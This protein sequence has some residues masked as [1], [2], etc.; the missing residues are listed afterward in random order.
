MGIGFVGKPRVSRSLASK[1]PAFPH[2]P[3][4]A[5]LSTTPNKMVAWLHDH[6]V[7]KG[8]TLLWGRPKGHATFPR[9]ARGKSAVTNEG[10]SS[11]NVFADVIV[12]VVLLDSSNV[13]FLS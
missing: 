4:Q 1:T 10:T 13:L 3:P 2:P 5:M 6:H 12:S 9:P 11:L 8:R 7:A